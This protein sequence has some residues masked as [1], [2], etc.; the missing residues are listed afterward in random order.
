[1]RC[2]GMLVHK[3]EQLSPERTWA[4]VLALR[5]GSGFRAVARFGRDYQC[6]SNPT[7]PVTIG[8]GERD[9][10]LPCTWL[11]WPASGFPRPNT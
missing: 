9:R 6:R 11:A 1:M 10:A 8:R 2:R 3:P 4:D 7:V 5:N